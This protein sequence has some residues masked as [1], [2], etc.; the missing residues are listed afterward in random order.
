MLYKEQPEHKHVQDVLKTGIPH[1]KVYMRR[2]P[3][4]ARRFIAQ[5]GN[6]EATHTNLGDTAGD[7]ALHRPHR[8]DF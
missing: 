4:Y 2:T 8:V 7:V 5:L 6:A 1:A 3:K